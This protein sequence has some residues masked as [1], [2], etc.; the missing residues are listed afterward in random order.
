MVERVFLDFRHEY[1]TLKC[2]LKGERGRGVKRY[3]AITLIFW[4]LLRI[5]GLKV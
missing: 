1:F 2:Y 4:K 3:Y 5:F